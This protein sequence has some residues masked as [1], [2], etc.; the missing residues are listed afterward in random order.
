MNN[1]I[2]R[3]AASALLTF[4][5]V[6]GSMATAQEEEKITPIKGFPD[7]SLT[8]FP[9]TVFWAGLEERDEGERAWAAAY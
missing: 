1:R 2:T 4:L 5:M 8:I 3:L 9:P 7:A 6:G